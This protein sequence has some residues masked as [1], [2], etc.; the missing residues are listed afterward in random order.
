MNSNPASDNAQLFL[1]LLEIMA[2]LRGPEGCPWDRKQTHSSLTPCLLEECYEVLDAIEK[3]DPHSL[4][5]ELGDLLLQVIFHAQIAQES[6]NFSIQQIL[7][8]LIE[9]LK[10]R[11][12]HVFS[13]E[14][15]EDAETAIRRWEKIKAEERPAGRSALAGLPKNLPALLRAYRLGGKAARLGFDWPH[16]SGVLEKIQEE[17]QEL[18]Q[19][20]QEQDAKN[21][22]AEFGDLLFSLAQWARFL[23]IDPE[24]ALRKA[25]LKFQNRFEHMEQEITAQHSAPE[26]LSAED[27]ETL[28]KKAKAF[29]EAV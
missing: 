27:W 15:I 22:E 12:P 23:K 9:K 29:T 8:T 16:V 10:R 4:Q 17:T 11:H 13:S 26:T 3:Q 5:E 28:W 2:T 7:K 20:F 25:N 18:Q 14:K 1:K 21:I 24:E 6:S 19:A